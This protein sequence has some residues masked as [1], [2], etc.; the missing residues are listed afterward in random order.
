M[1]E[2]F[3]ADLFARISQA[4]SEDIELLHRMQL[5]WLPQLFY[6]RRVAAIVQICRSLSR[7]PSVPVF[8]DR[9][10]SL[11]C[12][13]MVTQ[14]FCPWLLLRFG[15]GALMVDYVRLLVY[16]A[17]IV[18]IRC[19]HT[20][21]RAWHYR[22][23]HYAC[24]IEYCRD[25]MSQESQISATFLVLWP[26]QR[27]AAVYA[28][29][30]EDLLALTASLHVAM[31]GESVELLSGFHEDLNAA[32]AAGRQDI[33]GTILFQSNEDTR[34]AAQLFWQL[35]GQPPPVHRSSDMGSQAPAP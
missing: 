10:A 22:G 31:C 4:S 8:L 11:Y 32:Y 24:L 25:P 2:R 34:T 1:V 14:R 29:E 27:F 16:L 6:W 19:P 13:L 15:A 30:I 3:M 21:M 26:G 18:R 33:G 12:W 35:Y 5:N 28:R 17:D 23:S 20:V 7:F 9:I